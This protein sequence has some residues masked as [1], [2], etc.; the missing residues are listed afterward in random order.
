[1]R[2]A[3][4]LALLQKSGA[5]ALL[6]EL[7]RAD[8]LTGAAPGASAGAGGGSVGG[9]VTVSQIGLAGTLLASAIV[10]RKAR[11]VKDCSRYMQVRRQ[12]AWP[13]SHPRG[14]CSAG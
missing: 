8:S 5:D 9:R 12:P 14:P 7:P 6:F 3:V 2:L 4:R 11:F 1:V 10:E 13:G